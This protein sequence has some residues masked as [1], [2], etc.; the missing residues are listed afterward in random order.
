VPLP[1]GRSI[2]VS[3]MGSGGGNQTTNVNNIS[4]NVSASGAMQ[5]SDGTPT[6]DRLA[7]AITRAVQEEIIKQQRPGGLLR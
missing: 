2:P 7:R 6:G 3:L 5:Q 1:D 4:V